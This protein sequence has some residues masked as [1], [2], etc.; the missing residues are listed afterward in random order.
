MNMVDLEKT[1]AFLA[2]NISLTYNGED[3]QKGSQLHQRIQQLQEEWGL[4]AV[5]LIRQC[6][7][8]HSDANGADG[9][10]YQVSTM[11]ASCRWSCCWGGCDCGCA[12]C[13]C[14]FVSIRGLF[15]CVFHHICRCK[16]LLY[17][18]GPSSLSLFTSLLSLSVYLSCS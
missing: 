16:N 9:K 15:L 6:V 18:T 12:R 7:F 4:Y 1:D 14:F 13:C 10:V 11:K 17:I 8:E 2:G 5:S 3:A